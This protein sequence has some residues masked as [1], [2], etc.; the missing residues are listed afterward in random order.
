MALDA[1]DWQRL[2]VLAASRHR[3]LPVVMPCLSPARP[4]PL[5]AGLP[6]ALAW[7]MAL[8]NTQ[9]TAQVLIGISETQRLI[10]RFGEAGMTPLVFKGWP[11]SEDLYGTPNARH[12]GDIDVMIPP[13]RISESFEIVAGMGYRPTPSH[14]GMARLAGSR[15]LADEGKDVRFHNAERDTAIEIHWRLYPFHGWPDP[16]AL[17]EAE[18]VQQT[19][20]G[21][22]SVLSD[23]AN[24]L[25]L[26]V[27]GTLHLWTRLKWLADI[28]CLA[29]RRGPDQ[30]AEDYA[31]ARSLGIGISVALGLRLSARLLGSPLP[32]VLA[33]RMPELDWAERWMLDVMNRDDTM[34]G[35]TR[36]YRLWARLMAFRLAADLPQTLG[37]MRY[38]TVRRVRLALAR[39]TT[40]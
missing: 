40:A 39:M 1:D 31:L 2:M 28:A 14:A 22:L 16:L 7:K 27:H 6:E 8:Q 17:P 37:V 15:A 18:A 30:L 21:P 3:V 38:D 24:M 35:V 26:S 23:Q 20:I 29:H 12:M 25:Y 11:L 9:N 36:R 19:Q 32:G 10:A 34:P 33:G 5:Q 13:D 4:G